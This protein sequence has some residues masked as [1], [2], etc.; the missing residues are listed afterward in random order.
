MTKEQKAASNTSFDIRISSFS[1]R[2]SHSR[3][4]GQGQNSRKYVHRFR[5]LQFFDRD[6]SIDAEPARLH[7][8]QVLEM[9]AATEGLADVVGV[10]PDVKAFAANHAE[11]D[12]R[13]G[14]SIDCV[15]I[16]MDQARLPLDRLPLARQ[17]VERNAA[18]LDRGN[19]RRH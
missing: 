15:S 3:H 9:S 18:L 14:D 16:Y 5:G 17:F 8:P 11:I 10:S 19:H 4:F 7:P 12:L 13:R 2:P 6:R 1:S